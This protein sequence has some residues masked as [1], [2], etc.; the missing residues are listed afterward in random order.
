MKTISKIWGVFILFA[1]VFF[2]TAC[3]DDDDKSSYT[4]NGHYSSVNTVEALASATTAIT[5]QG[6]NVTLDKMLEGFDYIKPITG[7]E[8]NYNK[9]NIQLTGITD[10]GLTLKDFTVIINGYQRNMGNVNQDFEFASKEVLD[11]LNES[12]K[13]VV[14]QRNLSVQMKF[15]SD[16]NITAEDN[17]KLIINFNGV[18]TYLK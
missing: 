1:L 4:F 6:D 17:I 12:L 10:K 13:R 2:V 5:I 3:S 18:F 14:N 8:L 9:S 15:S 11:F 7:A 16:K